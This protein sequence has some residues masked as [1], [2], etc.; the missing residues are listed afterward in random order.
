MPKHAFIPP[1]QW[2]KRLARPKKYHSAVNERGLNAAPRPESATLEAFCPAPYDQGSLGSCTAN[3][4]CGA[5]R[6]LAKK[7]GKDVDF[8][9]SRLYLYFQERLLE[10]P[11]HRPTDLT[12]SGADVGDGTSYVQKKGICSES[13][14][15]YDVSKYNQ[16]PPPNCDQE[17]IG[18]KISRYHQIPVDSNLLAN[19]EPTIAG[20]SP[21]LIGI[22]VYD[23]FES[24]A[25]AQTGLVPVPNP[26]KWGNPHDSRDA[27]AGGHEMCLVGYDRTKRLFTVLNSWGDKWG[28]SG[29]CFI[30][31]DYLANPHIHGE[32][33]VF[34]L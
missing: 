20:G 1:D 19:I 7:N 32:F 27:Y 10:D 18:H 15:P 8:Q 16:V 33:T 23:S 12:D 22:D 14:W 13:S 29:L 3:A 28:K 30:P 34:Q 24:D 11:A 4:F 21:V 2:A 9:P 17:A 25:V 5:Y 31:Y 6:T 26:H